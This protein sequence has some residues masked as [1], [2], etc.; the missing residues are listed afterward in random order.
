[1]KKGF[2]LVELSI[3]LVVVGLLIGG[4]LVGQNLVR[5]TQ[6]SSLNTQVTKLGITVSQFKMRYK[7]VPGEYIQA[8]NVWPQICNNAEG[9]CGCRKTGSLG[10]QNG[11]IDDTYEYEGAFAQL[12][13]AGMMNM[14]RLQIYQNGTSPANWTCFAN[15]MQQS[16]SMKTRITGLYGLWTSFNNTSGLVFGAAAVPIATGEEAMALDQKFDDGLPNTG[17]IRGTNTVNGS[18]SCRY[19]TTTSAYDNRYR[20]MD[21]FTCYMAVGY[22][23]YYNTN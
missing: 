16:A 1:M 5:W 20:D 17:L 19:G 23:S 9:A 22:P 8:I 18:G 3:V 21:K 10:N 14:D 11:I 15:N 12:Q 7:A 13:A 6:V 4:I 2:T